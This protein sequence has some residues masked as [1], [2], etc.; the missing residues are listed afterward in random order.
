MP[1]CERWSH[2]CRAE[3]CRNPVPADVGTDRRLLEEKPLLSDC[4]HESLTHFLES[5]PLPRPLAPVDLFVDIGKHGHG[6]SV[7]RLRQHGVTPKVI[8]EQINRHRL[9]VVRRSAPSCAGGGAGSWC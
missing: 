7:A 9:N 3:P 5:Q 4:V 8:D 6:P 1:R 2:R